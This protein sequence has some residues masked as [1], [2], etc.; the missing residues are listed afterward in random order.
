MHPHLQE[1]L[2]GAINKV[3]PSATGLT[4][5]N[6]ILTDMRGVIDLT[7]QASVLEWQTSTIT[8]SVSSSVPE[9]TMPAVA[10]DEI[11]V[12][13][14]IS[15]QRLDNPVSG[16]TWIVNIE[17]PTME[18]LTAVRR[19]MNE[20]FDGDML[21]LGGSLGSTT[22]ERSQPLLVY[23][24]GILRVCRKD[25]V[26]IGDKARMQFV[27]CIIGGPARAQPVAVVTTAQVAK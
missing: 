7:P 5:I 24:Q 12:Y 26:T 13:H 27:R 4:V 9:W 8:M 1:F 16:S 10:F 25:S 2:A 17:Y 19:A 15:V 23:P 21:A 14:H 22:F 3:A 20:G 6:D 18:P 11:T